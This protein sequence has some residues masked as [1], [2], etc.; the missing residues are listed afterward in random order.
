MHIFAPCPRGLEELLVTEFT[1]CGLTQVE[2]TGGGVRARA[3]QKSLYRANLHSR[4]ASRILVRLAVGTYQKE[5]D[6][7]QMARKIA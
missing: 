5:E 3:T 6:L 4:Y 2:Q 7:Y 1:Q